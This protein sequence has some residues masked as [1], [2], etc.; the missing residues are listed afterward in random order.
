LDPTQQA[1]LKQLQLEK[2]RR[3]K[4]AEFAKTTSIQIKE[5]E[6]RLE[7]AAQL[8]LELDR[9]KE[10][11]NRPSSAFR[12][13]KLTSRFKGLGLATTSEEEEHNIC[14]FLFFFSFLRVFL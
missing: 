14:P 13:P 2:E 12:I 8:N 3:D 5:E 10:R 11:L 1:A 9:R 4:A 6:K 7:E